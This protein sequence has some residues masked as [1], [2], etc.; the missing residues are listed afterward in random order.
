MPGQT[1]SATCCQQPGP[2]RQSDTVVMQET[3]QSRQVTSDANIHQSVQLLVHSF[4][5][6]AASACVHTIHACVAACQ[7]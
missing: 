4:L 3:L 2:G 5:F 1:C 7:E 6:V